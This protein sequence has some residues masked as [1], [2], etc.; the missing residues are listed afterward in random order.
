M[1][2]LGNANWWLPRWME[3]WL[4]QLHVEGRPEAFLQP[5]PNADAV[6]VPA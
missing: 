5:D 6:A 1:H 3:R 2:L 4:P